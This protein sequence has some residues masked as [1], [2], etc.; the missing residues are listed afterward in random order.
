MKPCQEVN[1]AVQPN[2]TDEISYC[3]G[4]I[5]QFVK[6]KL[7]HVQVYS[8]AGFGSPC[9]ADLTSVGSKKDDTHI[10]NLGTSSY[11]KHGCIEASRHGDLEA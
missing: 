8:A 7:S 10:A 6:R 11:S 9:S 2:V 4:A 5:V 1:I 3:L